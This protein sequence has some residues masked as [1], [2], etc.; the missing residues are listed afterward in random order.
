[1]SRERESGD[2]NSKFD[3]LINVFQRTDIMV[4]RTKIAMVV[5]HLVK[6]FKLFLDVP[7]SKFK[8]AI[9]VEK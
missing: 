1:M 2:V 7:I 3:I 5:P 4:N 9:S 6:E 8:R